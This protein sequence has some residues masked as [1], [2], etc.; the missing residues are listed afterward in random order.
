MYR[1]SAGECEHLRQQN[2]LMV[3]SYQREVKRNTTRGYC[4]EACVV[5]TRDDE[6]RLAD[7]M[8]EVYQVRQLLEERRLAFHEE[9]TAECRAQRQRKYMSFEP[10]SVFHARA[11]RGRSRRTVPGLG[12]RATA[13]ASAA[14]AARWSNGSTC[15]A[16]DQ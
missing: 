15:M 1:D 14:A 5:R 7:A 10:C 12:G 8:R 9:C 4:S 11:R 16:H 3:Q 13:A 6:R 2:N